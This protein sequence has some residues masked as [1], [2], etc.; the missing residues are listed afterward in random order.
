[1]KEAVTLKF[2]NTPLT[3]RSSR[4]SSRFRRARNDAPTVMPR[5]MRGIQ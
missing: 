5:D 3:H 1:M 4:S 2:L